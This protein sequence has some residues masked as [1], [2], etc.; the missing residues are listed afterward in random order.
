MSLLKPLSM[1]KII[2]IIISTVNRIDAIGD[3]DKNV[4]LTYETK[5][6]KN[7]DDLI[8]KS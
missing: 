1:M 7:N 8:R 3:I 4:N 5:K 6:K 2:V